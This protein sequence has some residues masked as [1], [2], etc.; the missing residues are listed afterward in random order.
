MHVCLDKQL[1]L[2]AIQTVQRAVASSSSLPVLTGIYLKGQGE[3][4]ELRA[5]DLEI[6]IE[7][8]LPVQIMG[9]GEIVLPARYLAEVVRRFSPGEVELKLTGEGNAVVLSSS[10]ASFQLFG[11]PP[12]DFPAK[13]QIEGG[14]AWQVEQ[15]LFREMINKTVFAAA[16]D[17]LRPVLT[18][19]LLSV[20]G[21]NIQL[22]AS[23]SH[24][25]AV[26]TGSLT[27]ETGGEVK[28]VVPRKAMEELAR[29]LG[30]EGE[31]TIQTQGGQ[32][33]FQTGGVT[34][35]SRLIEGRFLD[36]RQVLPAAYKT[37]IQLDTREFLA[38][39]ERA[40]IL[41]QDKANSVR[42][43]VLADRIQLFANTPEVGKVEEEVPAA[44][45][46]ENTTISFNS[47]YL[48]EVLRV[49]DTPEVLFDITGSA[50]P[51]VIRPV[52]G[53]DYL[54]LIMPVTTRAAT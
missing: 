24:R 35:V 52:D 11:Y 12:G 30:E 31:V 20:Q 13:T 6:G 4:L 42:I 28:M 34:L 15:G 22:V 21:K 19:V 43:A 3:S 32:V 33:S 9:E 45:D 53:E 29:I 10:R 47:H 17:T 5:T 51:G 1:F 40:A 44:V 49:I 46:G 18:G 38:S 36:Y 7:C 26:Y 48:I 54:H 41:T 50:S 37:R 23:D 27:E 16:R 25:L 39:L 2:S 8:T 14:L